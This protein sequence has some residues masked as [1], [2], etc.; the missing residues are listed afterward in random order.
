MAAD[1][2]DEP[3]PSPHGANNLSPSDSYA[4]AHHDNNTDAHGPGDS[5]SGTSD[6]HSTK[7]G[8]YFRSGNSIDR[9]SE[10]CADRKSRTHDEPKVLHRCIAGADI[11]QDDSQKAHAVLEKPQAQKPRRSTDI[12]SGCSD[13]N[14]HAHDTLKK[15]HSLEYR[16]D[17]LTSCLQTEATAR[18]SMSAL[19]DHEFMRVGYDMFV[20]KNNIDGLTA[21][22]QQNEAKTGAEGGCERWMAVESKISLLQAVTNEEHKRRAALSELVS[23]KL[24]GLV[25]TLQAG[26]ASMAGRLEL[27]VNQLEALTE[28][29]GKVR[30]KSKRDSTS[31]TVDNILLRLQV[32]EQRKNT[33]K[34][35][36]GPANAQQGPTNSLAL[37]DVQRRLQALEQPACG[38]IKHQL[39]E[40]RATTIAYDADIDHANSRIAEL[41]SIV[42]DGG[43]NDR[44]LVDIELQLDALEKTHSS[45]GANG[46]QRH[47]QD[48]PQ[49][50]PQ[51][52]VSTPSFT[53]ELHYI[54]ARLARLEE[55]DPFP[56]SERLEDTALLLDD[57]KT[58]HKDLVAKHFD[59][60]AAC[61]NDWEQQ[62]HDI[63]RL[64]KVVAFFDGPRVAERLE[65]IEARLRETQQQLDELKREHDDLLTKHFD[66][67]ATYADDRLAQKD[68]IKRLE[69]TVE[70]LP[71]RAD[72]TRLDPNDLYGRLNDAADFDA[73]VVERVDSI[74][75]HK[76][77]EAVMAGVECGT[78]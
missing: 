12:I 2:A 6:K 52:C 64:D 59:L 33:A 49:D 66:L 60:A 16:L 4:T 55:V 50:H 76:G 26:H 7:E 8:C 29:L 30:E 17:T 19:Y 72:V 41:E 43:L 23:G 67:A 58:K 10:N 71:S 51:D 61:A 37:A 14:G 45:L 47:G 57:L 34:P 28:A 53:A 1:T 63:D 46:H 11:P 75:A 54:D 62:A 22:T 78:A 74:E 68:A 40:L 20:T 32:V 5:H 38:T 36:T 48:H 35:D 42:R 15:L 3:P 21:K 18:A 39:E 9:L 13:P 25:E 70:G 69:N 44:R 73:E 27:F 56:M 24:Q 65:A 77:E 31:A